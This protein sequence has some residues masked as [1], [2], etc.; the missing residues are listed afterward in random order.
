MGWNLLIQDRLENMFFYKKLF[1]QDNRGDVTLEDDIW[2]SRGSLSEEEAL[3]LVKSFTLSEIA[4]A[5]KDMGC[6]W[7]SIYPSR[8]KSRI[9]FWRSFSF[10]ILMD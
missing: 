7:A 3:T 10:S 8:I 1:G 2:Q 9:L 6:Q 5:L 4:C